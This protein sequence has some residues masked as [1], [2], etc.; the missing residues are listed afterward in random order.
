MT[1]KLNPAYKSMMLT[2]SL[3]ADHKHGGVNEYDLETLHK[4]M[5]SILQMMRE[6]VKAK[7][8]HGSS[9]KGQV[10]GVLCDTHASH[11]DDE[12]TNGN[13]H[14][15][16][17]I[18]AYGD[19]LDWFREEFVSQWKRHI[20]DGGAWFVSKYPQRLID[21]GIDEMV[22]MGAVYYLNS[23]YNLAER[24]R[25]AYHVKFGGHIWKKWERIL[26][27]NDCSKYRKTGSRFGVL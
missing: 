24:G 7:N 21:K 26:D 27:K 3:D 25:R 20:S 12:P 1:R 9:I 22:D 8:R 13:Y 4:K 15:H 14:V 10:Y 18:Y 5:R 2:L 17:L 6:K 11:A 16:L 19:S 23:N